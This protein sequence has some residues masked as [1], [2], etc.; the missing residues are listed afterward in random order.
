MVECALLDPQFDYS[1]ACASLVL[2]RLD[3]RG[4]MWMCLQELAQRLAQNTHTAAM[5][6]PDS[7]HSGKKGTVHELLHLSR[8]IVD[9][10]SNDVDLCRHTQIVVF[11]FE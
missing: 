7:W 10:L 1:C 11:V 8:G 9:G 5:D 6:N 4:N 2:S 3:H